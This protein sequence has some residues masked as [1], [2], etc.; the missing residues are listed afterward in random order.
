[1]SRTQTIEK[2]PDVADLIIDA[3]ERLLKTYGYQKMTMTDLAAEAG[4]GV[5]TTYLHFAS[6]VDVMVAVV[7][8]NHRI[9]F[10]QMR[11]IAQSQI[12]YVD[13][14]R[15]MLWL[16]ISDKYDRISECLSKMSWQQLQRHGAE[17]TNDIRMADPTLLDS[18]KNAESDLIADVFASGVKAGDFTQIDPRDASD[19]LLLATSAFMPRNLDQQ[20]FA[21]PCFF[22][23][24]VDKVISMLISG[25][26]VNRVTDWNGG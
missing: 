22:H 17:F 12:P 7:D 25:F 26:V 8:R 20:D 23:R 5:G 19:T 2:K 1:L 11:Q 14:I 21:D 24:Q 16:R 3:A 18:W 4:I 10:E 13:K 6:K 9:M 15:A